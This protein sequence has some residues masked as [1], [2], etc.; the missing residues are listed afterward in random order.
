MISIRILVF[1]VSVCPFINAAD[2]GST[3]IYGP[4][5]GGHVERRHARVMQVAPYLRGYQEDQV[6][7]DA[8]T[9]TPT[10]TENDVELTYPAQLQLTAPAMAPA[11][12][13]PQVQHAPLPTTPVLMPAQSRLQPSPLQALSNAQ[14]RDADGKE[15]A[16]RHS[17][18]P[19]QYRRL[20]Q[21]PVNN[22]SANAMHD[23]E[24]KVRAHQQSLPV[25]PMVPSKSVPTRH[26]P[27]FYERV[28]AE[29]VDPEIEAIMSNDKA[30]LVQIRNMNPDHY[31]RWY[32]ENLSPQDQ[33]IYL[34]AKSAEAEW[35]REN[36]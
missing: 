32:L 4:H 30:T 23:D 17:T 25:P 31:E 21:T 7:A 20:A 16:H 8:Q 36:S 26:I 27:D 13:G 29:V 14:M 24:A 22:M 28:Y 35:L 12:P 33:E 5:K 9:P 2:A 15:E 19:V 18:Q 34:A 1:A 6:I 11:K 10:R 3:Y